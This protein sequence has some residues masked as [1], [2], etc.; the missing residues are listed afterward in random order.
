MS[1]DVTAKKDIIE[2]ILPSNFKE[3]FKVA[4][5]GGIKKVLTLSQVRENILNIGRPCVLRLLASSVN[6]GD[7]EEFQEL[8]DLGLSKGIVVLYDHSST[9]SNSD[10]EE[11]RATPTTARYLH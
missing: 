11:V 5:D 3:G 4:L 1:F 6:T 10:S 9:P 2:A 8:Y 7:K